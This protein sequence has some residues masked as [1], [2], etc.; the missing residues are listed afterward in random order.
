[1]I[2]A[3]GLGDV[4]QHHGLTGLGRRDDQ[5]AL[6]PADGRDQIDGAGRDVL[7][8]AVADLQ[9]QPLLGEQRREVLEQDLRLGVLGPVEV[10]VVDLEQREIAL[11]VLG[12]TDLARDG[13]AG[14][15]REAPD[16]ARRDIDV[17]RPGQIGGIGR[18]QE[19]EPVRED[20]QHAVAVDVLA[21]LG[22]RL[23]DGEDQIL[24]ARA[25]DAFDVHGLSQ[26]HQIGHRHLLEFS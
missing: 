17:V 22:L 24:L 16:L 3:D 6:T 14:A 21:L 7:G 20:L 23:E 12:R 4:L 1:M 5:P 9:R 25:A 8:A 18:A 19:T 11:A 26:G 10:D 2:V 13:V 15:Q